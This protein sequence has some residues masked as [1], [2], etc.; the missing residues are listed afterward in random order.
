[1]QHVGGNIGKIL[2]QRTPKHV[3]PMKSMQ[4]QLTKTSRIIWIRYTHSTSHCTSS[5]DRLD[6]EAPAIVATSIPVPRRV[7]VAAANVHPRRPLRH[8]EPLAPSGSAAVAPWRRAIVAVI[9]SVAVGVA[10]LRAVR[11][12]WAVRAPDYILKREDKR[13]RVKMCVT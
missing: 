1:M 9:R 11:R 6:R 12:R 5:A 13:E 10:P 2:W 8:R 4:L 3:F 7:R